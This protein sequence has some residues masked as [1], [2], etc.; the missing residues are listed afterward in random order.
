MYFRAAAPILFLWALIFLSCS[1]AVGAEEKNPFGP[2]D[3]PL[4]PEEELIREKEWNQKSPLELQQEYENIKGDLALMEKRLNQLRG[5]TRLNQDQY[6]EKEILDELSF[7]RER[8]LR[9]LGKLI[10]GT[11]SAPDFTLPSTLGR[12]I[13]LMDF[14]GKK[15]LLLVF[16]LFDFSPT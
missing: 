6:R 7:I 12:K 3:E 10:K 8:E 1:T 13:G 4:I 5:E 2:F 9:I 11:E 15:N 16:Y 14:R